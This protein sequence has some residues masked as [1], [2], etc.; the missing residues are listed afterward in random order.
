MA[1]SFPRKLFGNHFL[2]FFFWLASNVNTPPPLVAFVGALDVAGSDD[3]TGWPGPVWDDMQSA[4]PLLRDGD[5][6]QQEATAQ[7]VRRVTVCGP[8]ARTPGV[9]I[10]LATRVKWPKIKF[11]LKSFS[12]SP[13]PGGGAEPKTSQ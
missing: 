10:T 13:R 6:Q 7:E 9:S 1:V 11:W 8:P 12:A 4:L 5:P 2:Q 3:V